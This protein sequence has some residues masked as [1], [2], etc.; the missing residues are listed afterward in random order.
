MFVLTDVDVKYLIDC[1]NSTSDFSYE[2]ME[3]YYSNYNYLPKQLIEFIMIF[4]K[5]TISF[6]IIRYKSLNNNVK[7]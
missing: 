1:Y 3:S 2:I 6:Y 4:N 5:K 7:L